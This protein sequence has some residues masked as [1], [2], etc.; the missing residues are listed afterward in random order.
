MLKK[1]DG[2]GIVVNSNELS[3]DK[4]EKVNDLIRILESMQLIVKCS[5]YLY[6]GQ[7][8][9][10]KQKAEIM[11]EFYIDKDIKAIFD[12]SGG[13]LANGVIEY[14][15]YDIIKK[16]PKPLFGYSDLTCLINTIYSQTHQNQV[17]YQVFN[18]V[19]AHQFQQ[20]YSFYQTMFHD[21]TYLYHID[22]QFIQGN[23]LK[24]IVVGGNIRCLLKLAGTKYFPDMNHKVLF[25]ESL[26]GDSELIYS[27]LV[28]LKQLNVFRQ[29]NGIVLGTF[30]NMEEKNLK[31][32]VEEML[33]ELTDK[34]IVKTYDIGH[35]HLSKALKI[36]EYVEF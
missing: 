23:Q 10:A 8:G 25:L 20:C 35:S 33:K 16:H 11:M 6:K 7:K 28:H 1:N 15:D 5:P 22:Y 31:P 32:T 36:G 21:L 12:I 27:H 34:P 17:L 29:V 4:K 24:G 9:N 26:G 3:I 30:T 14:L 13:N 18:L 19:K 2:I